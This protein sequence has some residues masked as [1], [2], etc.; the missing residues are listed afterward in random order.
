MP[1]LQE[2][3]VSY[4]VKIDESGVSRLHTLLDQNR[5]KAADTAA[6]FDRAEQ[7]IAS[8]G[9]ALTKVMQQFPQGG[10]LVNG[11]LASTFGGGGAESAGRGALQSLFST[12]SKS[13]DTGQRTR[14]LSRFASVLS[15]SIRSSVSTVTNRTNTYTA[16]NN[17]SG[18]FA[19]NADTGPVREAVD[20]LTRFIASK[21]PT[22]RMKG[23][24]SGMIAAASNAVN[25][26]RSILSDLTLDFGSGGDPGNDSPPPAMRFSS[27]GGRFSRPTTTQVAEDGDTE[28]IIPVRKEKKAVP[29][30][31]QMMGELS[32]NAY[33]SVLSNLGIVTPDH[34]PSQPFDSSSDLGLSA[35]LGDPFKGSWREAPEGFNSVPSL[36]ASSFG[37]GGRR[38]E[39][40]PASL[41]EGGARRA[42]GVSDLS[43]LA[44]AGITGIP[45]LSG[46]ASGLSIQNHYDISAPCT[47][48]VHSSGT[49][50]KQVGEAAYNAAE[51][52]LLKSIRGVFQ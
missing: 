24:A 15:E 28:F 12:D 16:G 40:V 18:S 27:A 3:L 35:S 30:I 39:G 9:K 29:L 33:Q 42:E 47:I 1:S 52:Q 14:E 31:T 22:M 51:R 32:F 50:A 44:A 45:S 2:M 19:L 23:D 46:F 8:F 17:T 25:R 21:A 38:P 6:A 4:A 48:Q 5:K 7:A 13:S 34:D 36:S 20:D 10:S 43:Y 11:F 41:F 26:V 49:D 37:G